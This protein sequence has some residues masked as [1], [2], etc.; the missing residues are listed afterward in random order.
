MTSYRGRGNT[1][2]GR[3]PDYYVPR[4]SL[5]RRIGGLMTTDYWPATNLSAAQSVAPLGSKWRHAASR[6]W[7]LGSAAPDNSNKLRVE[8]ERNTN[9]HSYANTRHGVKLATA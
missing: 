8:L 6:R 1:G 5:T 7:A 3:L 2:I 4:S 9:D